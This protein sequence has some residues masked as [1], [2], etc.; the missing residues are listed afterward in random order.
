MKDAVQCY[1]PRFQDGEN[2]AAFRSPHNSPNNIIHLHNVYPER[3]SL[4]GDE[5][6]ETEE[7]FEKFRQELIETSIASKQFI[8]KGYIY[9][10]DKTAISEAKEKLQDIETEELIS[11]LEKEK[12]ALNESIDA[13]Q[14]YRDALSEI[15][16]SH[17]K[18]IDERNTI[19]LIGSNYEKIILG[20]NIDDWILL[21]D[22]YI[23][24]N[25]EMADNEDLIKSHEEKIEIWEDEKDNWSSLSSAIDDE[26][27]KQAASQQFGADWESQVLNGR[28]QSFESFKSEYLNIESQINDNTSLINSY[29]EKITYYEDLKEQ[30]NDI[31]SAAE[32]AFNEQCAAQLLG[33][34]W[35]SKVLN[36]RLDTLNG[37]KKQY[38]K[39]QQSIADAAWNSANE[40]V[41]AAKEAQKGADG[42]IGSSGSIGSDDDISKADKGKWYIVKSQTGEVVDPKWYEEPIDAMEQLKKLN[43]NGGGYTLKKYHRGLEEGIVG[44]KLTDKESFDELL[45]HGLK[46]NEVPSVLQN[47]EVVLT[48]IQRWNIASDLKM[49]D[50]L[51]QAP[52]LNILDRS[53]LN[54]IASRN[55]SVP[56]SINIGDI[57]LHE[58]QNVEDLGQQIVKRL[59][60]A[61]LQAINKR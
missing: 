39:I 10:T 13:L 34:D 6:P 23:S 48:K 27:K 46:K 35:E 30:W 53:Y 51:I 60:N 18:L 31:S 1:T 56:L 45:K 37:F 2:L 11:S 32:L 24:A 54:N 52:K 25:D 61:M 12:D 28:L 55:N 50:N 33:A 38:M 15:S 36:G 7:E 58:V 19:E 41:K 8:G 42:N 26:A 9:D 4:Q 20:T 44:D 40:Q 57:Y 14:E 17:N 21:K 3:L 47:G 43:K 5:L 29:N 59:P 16:D 22:K 49:L